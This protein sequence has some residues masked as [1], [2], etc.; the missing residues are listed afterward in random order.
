MKKVYKILPYIIVIALTIFTLKTCD[1][2]KEFEQQISDLERK[3]DSI[4][5]LYLKLEN[6][7]D[8]V[9]KL[10]N[11]TIIEYKTIY[12]YKEQLQDEQDNISNVVY[13]FNEQ[14]LDSTIRSYK[15]TNR[16]KD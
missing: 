13:S 6:V 3:K 1:N 12:K 5:T 15:H 4:N 9:L 7:N 11:K 2:N 16:T 14:Q 10:K 8:S